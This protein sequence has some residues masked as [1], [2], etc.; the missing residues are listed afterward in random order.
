[1]TL[2]LQRIVLFY[3]NPYIMLLTK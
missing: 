3:L 1:M 2:L